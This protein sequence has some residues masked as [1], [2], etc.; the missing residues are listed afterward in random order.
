[1]TSNIWVKEFDNN[2]LDLVKQRRF[3]SYDY[4]SNFEKFKE[5]IPNN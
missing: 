4:I 1:M 2:T 3:Y 5:E